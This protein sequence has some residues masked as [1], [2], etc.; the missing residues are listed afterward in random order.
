MRCRID[1][2]TYHGGDLD[3]TSIVKLFGNS[4]GIFKG[5]ASG[6]NK[7]VI[8]PLQRMEIK[9]TYNIILSYVHYFIHYFPYQTF[10]L[11]IWLKHKLPKEKSNTV[12][13][14]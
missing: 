13:N 3:G 9:I 5:L 12:N 1:K 10:N 4:T 14:E 7:V 6:I 11:V 2:T 8:S